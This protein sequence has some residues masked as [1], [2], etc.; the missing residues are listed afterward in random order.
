MKTPNLSLYATLSVIIFAI[1]AITASCAPV[2]AGAAA[3]PITEL[4]DGQYPID[5]TENPTAGIVYE[6]TDEESQ[7]AAQ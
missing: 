7:G 4:S 1:S 3:E 5:W 2:Y 6:P